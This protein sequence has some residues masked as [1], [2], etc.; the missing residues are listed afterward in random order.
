MKTVDVVIDNLHQLII[1][2]PEIASQVA[3]EAAFD[4][5]DTVKQRSMTGEDARG[6]I[7][8]YYGNKPHED[9]VYSYSHGKKR[10]KKGAQTRVKDHSF[11]GSMWGDFKPSKTVKSDVGISVF[12]EPSGAENRLKMKYNNE[13]Q[14]KGGS[15]GI[16][17]PSKGEAAVIREWIA[18][19]LRDRIN[20]IVLG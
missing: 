3:T 2:L 16:A 11:T 10:E 1:L 19:E 5:A 7:F 20:K 6:D 9:G 17:E 13:Y 14:Q 8:G 15:T 4:L 18:D 12:V